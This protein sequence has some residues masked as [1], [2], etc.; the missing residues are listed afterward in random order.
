MTKVMDLPHG[1]ELWANPDNAEPRFLGPYGWRNHMEVAL[2]PAA[3]EIFRAIKRRLDIADWEWHRPGM[4]LRYK[5]L[6]KAKLALQ[7]SLQIVGKWEKSMLAN[8]VF[9]RS[10]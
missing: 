5:V 7:F 1:W 9:E 2:K 8:D 10:I 6:D 4:E 3:V